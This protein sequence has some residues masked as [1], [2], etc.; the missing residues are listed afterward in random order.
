M[1]TVK[2]TKM[3]LI[4]H[5]DDAIVYLF[6]VASLAQVQLGHWKDTLFIISMC[7]AL[8]QFIPAN[9]WKTSSKQTGLP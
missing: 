4:I 1:L 9:P 7:N 3:I 6:K 5:T 2:Q 8:N